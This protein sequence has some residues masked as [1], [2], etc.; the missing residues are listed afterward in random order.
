R[1]HNRFHVNL[2]R[3][4]FPSDATNFPNREEPDAYD[5]GAPDDVEWH[6]EEIVDHAWVKGT[7]KY[8][9]LVKWSIGE[10]TWEPQSECNKLAAMDRYLELMGVSRIADL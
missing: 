7:N 9:F 4:H 1:I 6:V 10:P 2:L 8:Q 5:F 3:P